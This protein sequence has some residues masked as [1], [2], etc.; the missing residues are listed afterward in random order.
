MFINI[1]KNFLGISLVHQFIDFSK[2]KNTN[3]ITCG[4]TQSYFI[5]NALNIISL[6]IVG[7]NKLFLI[8]KMWENI[9]LI[10]AYFCYDIVYILLV[11]P[12]LIFLVHHLITLLFIHIVIYIGIP[13]DLLVEYNLFCIIMEGTGPFLNFRHSLKGTEWE[14]VNKYMI[15]ITYTL[16]RII[17]YPIVFFYTLKRI[18][19]K[20]YLTELTKKLLYWNFYI[21][22]SMSV[23]WYKKIINFIKYI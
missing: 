14:K 23:I 11:S 4:L 1:L 6:D 22:Y 13:M 7:F 18:E 2:T 16:F 10:Y 19:N 5:I 3:T 15:F 17:M 9:Y 21:I 8:E 20:G 12:S